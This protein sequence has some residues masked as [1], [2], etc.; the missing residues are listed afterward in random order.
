MNLA[1]L[2]LQAAH[3]PIFQ[4]RDP[5]RLV[6][7]MMPNGSLSS[8]HDS[9]SLG[10]LGP[11]AVR[12]PR[13]YQGKYTQLESSRKF[14][15][16]RMKEGKK[17][18]QGVVEGEG[19]SPGDGV[20][21]RKT[22]AS[23]QGG[24]GRSS[25]SSLSSPDVIELNGADA[26]SEEGET[27]DEL[28]LRKTAHHNKATRGRP[29]S[30]EAW[31]D[32]A[33][34]QL[35]VATFLGGK[36]GVG[37]LGAQEKR[38]D[39][40]QQALRFLPGNERLLSALLEA[41]GD[42][43][44][45][46]TLCGRWQNTLDQRRGSSLLWNQYIS[47]RK[48]LFPLFKTGRM[49]VIYS[50]ALH[51]L[52]VE[53]GK[54]RKANI[55]HSEIQEREERLVDIALDLVKFEIEAG[56]VERAI[57][58][59]QATI[60]FHCFN[61]NLIKKGQLQ[62]PPVGAQ[63]RQFELFFES[64]HPMVGERGSKGWAD[65]FDRSNK[66]L[67]M[68]RSTF[69]SSG[70]EA[71]VKET[72]AGSWTGWEEVKIK[73]MPS[74]TKS[75]M[76]EPAPFAA[77]ERAE[78]E[79]GVEAVSDNEENEINPSDDGMVDGEKEVSDDDEALLARLGVKLDE[80]LEAMQRRGVEPRVF[81]RWL[82]MERD[83]ER[84]SWLPTRVKHDPSEEDPSEEDSVDRESFVMIDAV[85]ESVFPLSSPGAKERL[86]L[87]LLGLLG[88]PLM[89]LDGRLGDLTSAPPHGS[90]ASS[91]V[92]SLATLGSEARTSII[93]SHSTSADESLKRIFDGPREGGRSVWYLDD[94]SGERREF[95]SRLMS[96]VISHGSFTDHPHLSMALL[97][98][99]SSDVERLSGNGPETSEDQ[100]RNLKTA[101]A[102]TRGKE[103][104]KAMLEG[105]RENLS[106]GIAW[107]IVQAQCGKPSQAR[108][109]LDRSLSGA[110]A[111]L[112]VEKRSLEFR[113][114]IATIA[115]QY[116]EADLMMG[117]KGH[118]A[119]SVARSRALHII[120]WLLSCYI[121]WCCG[122]L[123]QLL[124]QPFQPVNASNQISDGDSE[125]KARGA[126]GG[127]GLAMGSWVSEAL[128]EKRD[129]SLPAAAAVICAAM[130]HEVILGSADDSGIKSALALFRN[131]MGS[132][133]TNDSKHKEASREWLHIR[134]CRLLVND[135]K[136][137][138]S[139][140][141]AEAR[142]HIINGLRLFP[143][144]P[145]LIELLEES[146]TMAH[147]NIRLRSTLYL[148][149]EA[150][151]NPLLLASAIRSEARRLGSGRSQ[152][153]I[154][155]LVFGALERLFEKAAAAPQLA[156]SPITW[157]WFIRLYVALGKMESARKVLLRAIRE[158]PWSKDLVWMEGLGLL[159]ESISP[160]EMADLLNVASEKGVRVRVDVAEAM[161]AEISETL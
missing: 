154:P 161:L 84:A 46:E 69:G 91:S 24:G 137:R 105:N 148:A 12:V 10:G 53:L 59:I 140:S 146:D 132:S 78:D 109:I 22:N 113:L 104:V 155:S 128:E 55:N 27:L 112:T 160:K 86:I 77:Q 61:P 158:C 66:D 87:S 121:P 44:D 152:S 97:L 129:E 70:E 93:G 119:E 28:I 100:T 157:I 72:E 8:K 50:D 71:E 136:G 13:Y 123:E 133:P 80:D 95:L 135:Q 122:D 58:R 56:F 1:Y 103:C 67:L 79:E 52:S 38:V 82:K 90:W 139:I 33:A 26:L 153:S 63:L 116:A 57:A 73:V 75:V 9:N 108:S 2:C 92:S 11:N 117:E 99:N 111:V 68:A 17:E 32:F 51:D 115:L 41:S 49:Q 16:I 143:R 142:E 48:S 4:R 14:N 159:H 31:M 18:V 15:R 98:V 110:T 107:G 124:S 29:H 30:L 60:E 101:L 23:T 19:G 25:S 54:R 138:C 102:G 151:P 20:W 3:T 147:A 156:S 130:Y 42:L 34:F 145:D 96:L 118:T 65:W 125:E 150:D 74:E 126:R 120:Q 64:G 106:L 39:I 88:A 94:P 134:L 83:G 131:T 85:R 35:E 40:L 5:F 76:D 36:R 149:F 6:R 47:Y 7:G 141:P 89:G 21:W 114:S 62:P 43:M 127:F 45:A 144:S 37:M 81:K